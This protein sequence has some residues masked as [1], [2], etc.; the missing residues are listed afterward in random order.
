MK[1]ST[2]SVSSI[3]AD[4]SSER[5]RRFFTRTDGWDYD[6]C[7]WPGPGGLEP[8]VQQVA[9]APVMARQLA[10]VLQ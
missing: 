1:L 4:V 7:V 6:A 8:E 10:L 9:S 3:A 2:D 5:L